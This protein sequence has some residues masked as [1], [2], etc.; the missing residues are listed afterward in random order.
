MVKAAF[1]GG[2]GNYYFLQ[3]NTTAIYI[4]KRL[5]GPPTQLKKITVQFAILR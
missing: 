4:S 1:S 2:D 3:A 5:W